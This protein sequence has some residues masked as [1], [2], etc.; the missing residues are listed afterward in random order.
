MIARV[1]KR[2]PYCGKVKPVANFYR[3]SH[4]SDGLQGKCKDCDSRWRRLR[5]RAV[6]EGKPRPLVSMGALGA[7]KTC[8]TCA[9]LAHRVEGPRCLECGLGGI[10]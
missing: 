1:R 7:R 3:C 10:Q 2:C 6:K 8:Q 9:G 5:N 4:T